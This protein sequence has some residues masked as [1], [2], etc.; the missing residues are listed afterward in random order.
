MNKMT[1][2]AAAAALTA[3]SVSAN[4][5]YGWGPFDGVGDVF[6]DGRFDMSF[7]MGGSARSSLYGYGYG[8][9]YY[10]YAPYGVY[11][12]PYAPAVNAEQ[13]QTAFAEQQKA[14]A[15]Q[16]AKA[17]EA[18]Q[19]MAQQQADAYKQAVEAQRQYAGQMPVAAD[20]I[21]TLR[22]DMMKRIGEDHAAMQQEMIALQQEMAEQLR[23]DQARIWEDMRNPFE[24]MQIAS[25]DELKQQAD[26]RRAEAMKEMDARRAE[27]KARIE[28]QRQTQRSRHDI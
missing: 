2:I 18:Y 9:P 7:S 19:Q 8:A 5:W 28:A 22:D 25:I 13:A 4:A 21:F 1:K 27:T 16:Q 20:P 26:A 3:A 6:G 17:V 14:F 10:G 11:G 24:P 23:Q 15:E 12:A